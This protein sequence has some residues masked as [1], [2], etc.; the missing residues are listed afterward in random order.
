M[1]CITKLLC[2]TGG[3][4]VGALGTLSYDM[5]Q[6]TKHI[7]EPQK[8][9][10]LTRMYEVAQAWTNQKNIPDEYTASQ[11]VKT[12]SLLS[13]KIDQRDFSNVTTERERAGKRDYLPLV[14]QYNRTSLSPVFSYLNN[15]NKFVFSG[16]LENIK[17]S[18]AREEIIQGNYVRCKNALILEKPPVEK[19]EIQLPIVAETKKTYLLRDAFIVGA[20]D[21]RVCDQFNIKH[22]KDIA[23]NAATDQLPKDHLF[24]NTPV[25]AIAYNANTRQS[26]FSLSTLST[27]TQKSKNDIISGRFVAC[28]FRRIDQPVPPGLNC[29]LPEAY[30]VGATDPEV[31]YHPLLQN[32]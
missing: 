19:S 6:T 27:L 4:I 24:S 18:Q 15:G 3:A 12:V 17:D 10:L 8:G 25:L 11:H 20:K 26:D 1:S 9:S 23:F 13:K 30:V 22:L 32:C 7:P 14:F 28:H 21:C 16:D 31:C 29:N 5:H 2:L